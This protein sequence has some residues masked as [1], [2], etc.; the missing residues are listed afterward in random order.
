MRVAYILPSLKKTG[1]AERII[2]EKSNYLAKKFGYDI[3]IIT[4]FQDSNTPNSYPL[5]ELVHQINL[6]IPYYTQYNYKYPKRLFIKYRLFKSMQK[7]LTQTINSIDPDILIGVSYSHADLVCAIPC[8]AKKIIECHEPRD[9]VASSYFNGS[10]ISKF[11]IKHYY[12]HVIEKNADLVVTL[13]NKDKLQ[14]HKAKCVEVI[15]NFSSMHI[16]HYSTCQMKRVIAVGRL[17]EEKGFERLIDIWKAVIAKHPDWKLDIFGEGELKNRLINHIKI[18][19]VNNI[20]LCGTTSNISK[21]YSTS[22]ICVVT[23]YFEGFS[24]VILEAMKHGV[25]CVA[26]DCPFGPAN[27]IKDGSCGFLIENGNSPMFTNKLSFLMENEDVRHKF[28]KEC[29][30]QAERYNI[31][32]IMRQWQN[33]FEFV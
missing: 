22:S 5:S 28:S 8:R 14:W 27:I 29:L 18:K 4:L 25:P 30:V 32:I 3:Y 7:K 2:T 19:Q 24:L 23:S 20:S 12:F 33:L 6:N 13:T 1:G 31:D 15:P 10:F 17:S 16:T 9:L 26:F 11:R 21:E